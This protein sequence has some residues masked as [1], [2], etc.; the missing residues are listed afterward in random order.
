MASDPVIDPVPP[1]FAFVVG[2]PRSG[3]TSL[4][5]Y[6]RNHPGVCFSLVKEPHYFSAED[7]SAL[8]DDDLRRTVEAD[9]LAR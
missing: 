3:T 8:S 5:G 1:H 6:L 4:S 2:A 7:L 9:Y